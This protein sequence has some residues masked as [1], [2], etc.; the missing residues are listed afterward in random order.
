[1][2]VSEVSIVNEALTL[3]GAERIISLS[4]DGKSARLMNEA[5]D[6]A[7]DELLESHPWRFAVKRVALAKLVDTP[8]YQYSSYFQIPADCLR[9]LET[10]PETAEWE[11]EGQLIAAN[12]DALN[13]KYIARITQPGLFSAK[14]AETLAAKLA[15]IARIFL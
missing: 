4:D 1:V 5:F 14:F 2:S 13:V 11:R 6:K 10:D 12:E 15:S 7:R 9:V 3:I 8:A